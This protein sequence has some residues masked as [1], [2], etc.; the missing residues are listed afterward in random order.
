M[1]KFLGV[2]ILSIILILGAFYL[3]NS[4]S[5]T[6]FNEI[7]PDTAKITSI[8]I[9]KSS[10]DIEAVIENGNDIKELL[11]SLSE[12]ELKG[13][14]MGSIHFN[15]SYWITLST[16]E[17]RQVGITVYDDKYLLIFDYNENKQTTY[18]IING[19]DSSYIEQFFN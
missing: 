4:R 7:V 10:T 13:A 9:I 5:S 16:N 1:K 19:L 12:A 17:K 2:G 6:T 18:Q 3:I 11:K 8:E 14:K 15:E